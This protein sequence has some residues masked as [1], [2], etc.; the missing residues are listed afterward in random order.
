[1][2]KEKK[3]TPKELS[4]KKKYVKLASSIIVVV[5]FFLYV[6]FNLKSFF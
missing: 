2:N 6:F 1:M 3:N 5:L 4:G